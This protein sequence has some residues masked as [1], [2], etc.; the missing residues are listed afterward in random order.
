MIG[1]FYT[2]IATALIIAGLIIAWFLLFKTPQKKLC[3]LT[4]ISITLTI[5][6]ILMVVGWWIPLLCK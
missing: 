4:T 1:W 6:G 2:L 5:A 3:T